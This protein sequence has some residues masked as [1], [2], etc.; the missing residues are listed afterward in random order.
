MNESHDERE[1]RVTAYARTAAGFSWAL[2]PRSS[3]RN[4]TGVKLAW[5]MTWDVWDMGRMGRMR[6]MGM[7]RMGSGN[8]S[9][10]LSTSTL[11][12]KPGKLGTRNPKRCR[13]GNDHYIPAAAD[14]R[15]LQPDRRSWRDKR[16]GEGKSRQGGSIGKSFIRALQVDRPRPEVS[17][18]A[19]RSQSGLPVAREVVYYVHPRL[20]PCR[21]PQLNVYATCNV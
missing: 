18:M 16:P 2:G 3:G 5:V 6:R 10:G 1:S 12:S 7:G 13:V 21:L 19:Y 17:P 20:R 11:F 8:D 4:G 9:I 15:T 14:A